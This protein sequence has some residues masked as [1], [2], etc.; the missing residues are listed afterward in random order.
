M[1]PGADQ[2]TL[3]AMFNALAESKINCL[4]YCV[5]PEFSMVGHRDSRRLK[6]P[7]ATTVKENILK[8]ISRK[9]MYV[10]WVRSRPEKNFRH[11]LS[12]G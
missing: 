12:I 1:G 11:K 4:G 10:S 6:K 5:C 3:I 9:N 7:A 2:A 8:I